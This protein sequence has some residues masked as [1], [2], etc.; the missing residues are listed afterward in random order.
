MGNP[1]WTFEKELPRPLVAYLMVPPAVQALAPLLAARAV[2]P[3]K[4]EG[5]VLPSGL[6]P[7]WRLQ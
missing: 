3:G 7:G 6:R 1:D 5:E 2:V 4:L